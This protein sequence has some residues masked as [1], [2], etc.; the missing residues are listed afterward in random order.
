MGGLG[1]IRREIVVNLLL[2]LILS[3]QLQH[4]W[5]FL[6]ASHSR[7]QPVCNLFCILPSTTSPRSYLPTHYL[8]CFLIELGFP[9]P[10]KL[11]SIKMQCIN[12]LFHQLI[13][14]TLILSILRS[15]NLRNLIRFILLKNSFL[16][17]DLLC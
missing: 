4:I 9:R 10:W 17:K 15:W 14:I 8:A 5:S 6:F 3:Y 2:I 12:H 1:R 13:N 16:H 11:I 7:V